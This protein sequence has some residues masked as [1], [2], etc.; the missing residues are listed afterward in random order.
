MFSSFPYC[1]FHMNTE[2]SYRSYSHLSFVFYI[3]KELLRKQFYHCLKVM[4][5]RLDDGFCFRFVYV[6]IIII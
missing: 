2:V 3:T 4:F 5:D 1:A 6:I